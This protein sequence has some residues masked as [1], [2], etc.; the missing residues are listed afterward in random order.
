MHHR[1]KQHQRQTQS[2]AIISIT[3][4]RSTNEGKNR[5]ILNAIN[6]TSNQKFK[7]NQIYNY[8]APNGEKPVQRKLKSSY[9]GEDKREADNQNV[10]DGDEDAHD[11]L[12]Q[13]KDLGKEE[14]DA[15]MLDTLGLHN[16]YQDFYMQDLSQ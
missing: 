9:F 2:N 14:T 13:M 1:S 8:D 5:D 6:S 16:E 7:S 15:A 4:N 3:H 10:D 12:P 11:K